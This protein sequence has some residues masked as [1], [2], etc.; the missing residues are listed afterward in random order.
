MDSTPPHQTTGGSAS[1][2]PTAGGSASQGHTAGEFASQGHTAGEFASQG[3]RG[4]ESAAR[5]RLLLIEDDPEA[6]FFCTYVLSKRGGFDVTHVADPTVALTLAVT[7]PWD[8]VIADLDLPIMSGLEFVAALRRMAPWLPVVLV[9][10]YP[11]HLPTLAA[12]E[13]ARPP[14]AV[15]T[16]PVPADLLLSTANALAAPRA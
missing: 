9:T 7:R 1:R 2:G 12:T 4:A 16:K 11:H 15:L 6:A 13:R 3:Q 10:A 5:G 14:D 8:L